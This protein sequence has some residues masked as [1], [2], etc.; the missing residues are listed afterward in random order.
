MMRRYIFS[1]LILVIALMG[2]GLAVV[3]LMVSSYLFVVGYGIYYH[4]KYQKEM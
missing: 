1:A 2:A 3:L 4:I